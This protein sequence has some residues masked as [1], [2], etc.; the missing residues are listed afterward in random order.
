MGVF[1]TRSPVRPNPIAISPVPVMGIDE[2][3]GMIYIPYIDAEDATPI[4]DLKPYHPC[5]DRIKDVQVPAW[6]SH[7]PQ[8]Y[9]ESASFDWS[10]E[11]VHAQ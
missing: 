9:E 2:D 7:W 11:F 8:S 1:A 4:V 5:I 10:A 3:H 6:C